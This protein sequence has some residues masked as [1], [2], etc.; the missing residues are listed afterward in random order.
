MHLLGDLDS[1][2][3]KPPHECLE[4]VFSLLGTRDSNFLS[5]AFVPMNEM[6]EMSL[7]RCSGL[8][9]GTSEIVRISVER[10]VID[11]RLISCT[12]EELEPGRARGLHL[13]ADLDE[14]GAV[15]YL[16]HITAGK[17]FVYV[18]KPDQ[19]EEH[20]F[21]PGDWVG[22]NDNRGLGHASKVGPEGCTRTFHLLGGQLG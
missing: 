22:F 10:K 21:G 5:M 19:L 6:I 2:G 15:T 18:G 9:D 3:C 8:S 11:E 13:A 12:E 7:V 17:F 14:H 16:Q 20:V 1:D 4:V